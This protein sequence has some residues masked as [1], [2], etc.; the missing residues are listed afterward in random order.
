MHSYRNTVDT[1]K[2]EQLFSKGNIKMKKSDIVNY[3]TNLNKYIAS[4]K[5]AVATEQAAARA[6][7]LQL[8]SSIAA[9]SVYM[10]KNTDKHIFDSEFDFNDK[11]LKSYI[12]KYIYEDNAT[13]SDY[14]RITAALYVAYEVNAIIKFD[15]DINAACDKF[16]QAY[17][18]VNDLYIESGAKKS[19]G[20]GK[21]KEE[22]KTKTTAAG[23][24]SDSVS[25][26]TSQKT[27]Y[28]KVAENF[29]NLNKLLT[30]VEKADLTPE[31]IK[32]VE[33]NLSELDK[34]V[35][36]VI[37]KSKLSYKTAKKAA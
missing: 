1:N 10:I 36:I 18:S 30:K 33:S 26:S 12:K 35:K 28:Q 2:Q 4:A 24:E 37:A 25:E 31:F 27:T 9:L 15:D 11:K 17:A 22:Q 14:M 7:T 20:A 13:R 8:I 16:T 19:N 21:R 3:T 29:T 32:L 23:V 6:N 34:V 5:S